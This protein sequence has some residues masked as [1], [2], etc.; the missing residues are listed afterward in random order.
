MDKLI[1][2]TV[3]QPGIENFYAYET[4]VSAQQPML[5]SP[6]A[7]PVVLVNNRLHGYQDFV[8]PADSLA[9]DQLYCTTPREEMK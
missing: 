2:A 9:P 3:D 8:N 6:R 5:F 4:Y 7:R 1:N